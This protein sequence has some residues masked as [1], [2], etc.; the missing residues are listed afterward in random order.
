MTIL[1]D[2]VALCTPHLPYKDSFDTTTSAQQW[3]LPRTRD[4]PSLSQQ[5]VQGNRNTSQFATAPRSG[6]YCNT[7]GLRQ[8]RTCL[9][10]PGSALHV[11]GDGGS[12]RTTIYSTPLT[13][14]PEKASE[15]GP[16]IWHRISSLGTW[17]ECFSSQ[18]QLFQYVPHSYSKFPFAITNNHFCISENISPIR[19]LALGARSCVSPSGLYFSQGSKY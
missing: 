9:A 5:P 10:S 4:E 1:N 18:T 19:A 8:L 2:L 14:R 13:H 17:E 16:L 7:G 15:I 6:F 11:P 12:R 3:R